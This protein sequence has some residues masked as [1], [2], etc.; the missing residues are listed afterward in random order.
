MVRV[1]N[2]VVSRARRKK[3]VQKASGYWGRNNCC[4]KLAKRMT[5]RAMRYN[6]RDRRQRARDFRTLWI[7][8]TNAFARQNGM[9]YSTFR[10][11]LKKIDCDLNLKMIAQMAF[12]N[13]VALKSI[14]GSASVASAL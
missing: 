5:D 7:Q 14:L 1:R 4:F 8:R 3:V 12:E 6:Y 13:P 11:T 2:C 9:N 10:D